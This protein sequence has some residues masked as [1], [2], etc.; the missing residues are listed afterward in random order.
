[1][2]IRRLLGVTKTRWERPRS[3]PDVMALA[4]ELLY[5]ARVIVVVLIGGMFATGVWALLAPAERAGSPVWAVRTWGVVCIGYA[6]LMFVLHIR[7]QLPELRVVLRVGALV[8]ALMS[9]LVV[10][11]EWAGLFG[12]AAYATLAG[13][14]TVVSFMVVPPRGDGGPDALAG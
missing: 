10:F 3:L 4:V 9:L 12:V 11:D 2:S 8:W 5:A 14:Q 1:V 13:V 6:V 7:R